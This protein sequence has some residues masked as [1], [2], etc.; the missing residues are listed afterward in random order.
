MLLPNLDYSIFLP[1]SGELF[2]LQR[3][4]A[5][6]QLGL[7]RHSY[8]NLGSWFPSQK[9]A[10][11]QLGLFRHSYLNLGS[12]FPSRAKMLLPAETIPS[13]LPTL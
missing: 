11:I 3:L 1:K 9:D 4:D 5:T 12:C 13:C 8:L 7:L 6:V 2:P 10:V